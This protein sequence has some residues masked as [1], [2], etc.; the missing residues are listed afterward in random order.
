MMKFLI[1]D[2]IYNFKMIE[3]CKDEEARY[4]IP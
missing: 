3:N 2:I 1:N 4:T